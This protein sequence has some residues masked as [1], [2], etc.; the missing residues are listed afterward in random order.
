MASTPLTDVPRPRAVER[1]G[2]QRRRAHLAGF[3]RPTVVVGFLGLLLP[4]ILVAGEAFVLHAPPRASLSAYY[5]SGMR[6]PY[7]TILLA[8]SAV[9]FRHRVADGRLENRV[10]SVA[11]V[12]VALIALC[13][14]ALPTGCRPGHGT[15]LPTWCPAPTRLQLRLGE[16]LLQAVHLG[17]TYVCIPCMLLLAILFAVRE[18][19]GDRDG[20][21]ASWASWGSF[22]TRWVAVM[23]LALTF[24]GV[25]DV[26]GVWQDWSLTA[27]ESVYGIAFSVSWCANGVSTARGES[28]HSRDRSGRA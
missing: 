18:G 19:K 3:V 16:G 17:A 12:A 6:T 20:E 21:P 22:H 4:V 7:V 15:T 1:T 24:N 28:R 23:T 8:W 11:G 25:T 13:P 9:L 10:S 27:A 2:P 14:T 5:H 26:L